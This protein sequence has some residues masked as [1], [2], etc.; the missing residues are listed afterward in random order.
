MDT[1]LRVLAEWKGR[2]KAAQVIVFDGGAEVA[3]TR[4]FA[5][6]AVCGI[7]ITLAVF[8]LTA[9]TLT[10]MTAQSE[11]EH[12]KVLLEEANRRSEQAMEISRVCLETADHLERTLASYQSFLGNSK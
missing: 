9:P 5:R 12:R 10:D 8:V 4:A 6:G 1:L 7:L 11:M 2:R 3:V